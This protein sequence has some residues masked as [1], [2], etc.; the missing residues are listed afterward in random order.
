MQEMG[1]E[2]EYGA[3]IPTWF[4]IGGGAARLAKPRNVEELQACLAM[5]A[6]MRV[7]GDGANLLVHDDGVDELVVCLNSQGSAFTQV[8]RDA[9]SGLTIAGAGASLPKLINEAVRQ[10]LGGLE[11]LGGIPATIGGAIMMN[12][13]G[14]FG[15]IADVVVRVHAVDRR[16]VARVLERKD[17]HFGYRHSGLQ[18]LI[19]TS[20][21]LELKPGDRDQ[22][23]TKH[24]DVMAFKSASQPMAAR[25]AGCVFKNPT[26]ECDAPG[27]GA[28]GHRVSAGML[29]DRAG[30][31]GLA[32]G[33]ASVS[34][35]HG[36]FIV[37]EPATAK[38]AHVLELMDLVR[39]RV[40]ERFALELEPEVVVWR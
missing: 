18:A 30:C 24:R 22:L 38:A 5:D 29:I 26:L 19:V 11:G 21:E 8:R 31:K 17:I 12:A 7:L 27:F 40:H 39:A 9:I 34:H 3:P 15:Q 36:N 23:R 1:V 6:E 33:G 35:R 32:V 10:G 16:G 28:S 14:A 25:S 13:G 20:V 4:G 2:I 37:T